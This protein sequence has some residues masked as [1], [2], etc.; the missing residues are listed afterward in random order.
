M[1][2]RAESMTVQQMRTFCSV[3]EHGG[4][5]NAEKHLGLAGPTLW[6]HVK[7]LEMIYRRIFFERTGRNVRP[8]PEGHALYQLLTSGLETTNSRNL[9]D[10]ISHTREV[11][12]ASTLTGFVPPSNA[13]TSLQVAPSVMTL[14]IY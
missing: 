3:Y 13:G 8:T 4:Y 10:S 12:S 7:T 5:S 14:M 6:E 1:E 2:I 9:A 11:S